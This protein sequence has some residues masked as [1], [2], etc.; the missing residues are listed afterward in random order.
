MEPREL[1]GGMVIVLP[2]MVMVLTPS[3]VLLEFS[4][5]TDFGVGFISGGGGGGD[6]LGLLVTIPARGGIVIVL[7]GIT[8]FLAPSYKGSA[9]G[10]NG[11]LSRPNP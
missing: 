1:R 11:L 6:I 8:I 9:P 4:S 3:L 10:G 7:L 2:P 5:D